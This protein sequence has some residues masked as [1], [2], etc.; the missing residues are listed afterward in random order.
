VSVVVVVVVVVITV[1]SVVIVGV[2]ADA[3]P[4][5]PCKQDRRRASR[6]ATASGGVAIGRKLVWECKDIK[7]AHKQ[8]RCCHISKS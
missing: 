4:K 2:E 8:N 7:G 3:H 5:V 6:P 1:V